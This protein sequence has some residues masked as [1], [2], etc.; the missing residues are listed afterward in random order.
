MSEPLQAILVGCGSI[1]KTWLDALRDIP[2]VRIAGLIDI[3][4]EAA[5][6]RAEEYGLSQALIGTDLDSTLRRLQP[7]VMSRARLYQPWS[8]GVYHPW[9]PG[10]YQ[11]LT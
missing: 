5:R 7:D 2:E 10:V 1:T 4:E 9:S 8:P 6:A 11:M 3:R